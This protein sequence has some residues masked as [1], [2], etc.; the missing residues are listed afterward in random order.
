MGSIFT[1]IFSSGYDVDH[2]VSK[3]DYYKSNSK[4]KD[5][6]LQPVI[7]LQCSG[8]AYYVSVES[9]VVTQAICGLCKSIQGEERV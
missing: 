8:I 4:D 5:K 2:H 7:C 3:G 9:T 6:K 1:K